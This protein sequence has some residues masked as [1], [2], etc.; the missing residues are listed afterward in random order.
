MELVKNKLS[1]CCAHFTFKCAVDQFIHLSWV[2]WPADQ[3]RKS[4]TAKYSFKA[5]RVKLLI[6]KM[7]C[8]ID[9][10]VKMQDFKTLAA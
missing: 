4:K 3:K 5:I 6:S 10:N 9:L 1:L 8:K 7:V 2:I